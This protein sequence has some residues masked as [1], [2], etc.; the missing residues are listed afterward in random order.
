MFWIIGAFGRA[1][2]G[3]GGEPALKCFDQGSSK[4]VTLP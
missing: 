1:G 4:N 2:V 3:L